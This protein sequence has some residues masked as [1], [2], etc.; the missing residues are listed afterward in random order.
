MES[1]STAQRWLA[2]ALGT[3]FLVFI[4]AG[5]IPAT[6]ILG[7]AG[8][9]AVLDGRPG[10]DL[11]RVHA[12]DRRHGLRHRAHLRLPHQPGGHGGARR[13]RQVRPGRTCPATSS[14]RSSARPPAH[15]PSSGTLGK[16]AADLGLGMTTYGDSTPLGARHVRRVHRHRAAGLRHLRRHRRPRRAGLGRARDRLDRLRH[17]HRRRPG[18]RCGA[19]PGP[20]RRPDAHRRAVRRHRAVVA[21]ARRTSSASSSARS[22]APSPTS[23]L[24]QDRRPP[25]VP[26]QSSRVTAGGPGMKKLINA[27]DDVVVEALRGIAAAHPSLAVDVENKVI[28]RAGGADRRQGRPGLRRRLRARAAARRLRRLR[29]ARRRLPRRG[30]HLAGAGPDARRHQGRRRRRGRAAHREELHRRRPQLPDGRRAGRRRRASRSR[31]VLV[32]DDV[33]VQDSLYTA[34]RRGTGATVF[35]EK[36]AGALAEQRRGAQVGGRRGPRGQRALPVVRRRAHRVHHAGLRAA[37]LRP[38]RRRDRARRRHPRRARPRA[39]ADALGHARS[40][41]SRWTRSTTTMPLAGRARRDG[42]RHGRHPAD[43]A[44]RGLR[45]GRRVAR[46]PRAPPSPAPWSAT[47]SPASTWPAPRSPCCASPRT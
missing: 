39:R 36:I 47:T 33:A 42:Q 14:R 41:T 16:T 1:N 22:P 2:E 4:G 21:A 32:N 6:L 3:G 44:V 8:K 18:D 40:S 28:T 11:V 38:A 30:V 23:P 43:R 5:S 25:T 24:A 7:N 20:L 46:R 29:H 13:D 45:R 9:V 15:W 12:G 34:G 31:S 27:P 35:V 26:A 17:H 37:R 19:Q 10:D